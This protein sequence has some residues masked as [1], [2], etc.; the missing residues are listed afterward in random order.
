MDY[1]P[2]CVH[3]HALHQHP[4]GQPAGRHVRVRV[5]QVVAG[6][7]ATRARAGD[8]GWRNWEQSREGYPWGAC[9]RVKGVGPQRDYIKNTVCPY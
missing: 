6:V 3:L 2:A 4:A 9:G 5:T 1:Y 8:R 7:S